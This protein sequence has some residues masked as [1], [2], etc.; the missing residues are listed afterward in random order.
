MQVPTVI[1]SV[2]LALVLPYV[3]KRFLYPRPIPGIPYDPISVKRFMGD[4]PDIA[5][6]YKDLTQWTV[7]IARRSL[8]LGSPI[9]QVFMRPFSK[10]FVVVD[11]PREVS[12]I[13]NRRNREFDRTTVHGVWRTLLPFSTIAQLSTP[14]FKAQRKAWQDAMAPDF[15]RRVVAGHVYSATAGLI[16]LWA[17]RA[18]QTG[19]RPIDVSE[20]FSF[21]ALDAIW[22]ATFGENLQLVHSEIE[23]LQTGKEPD[24]KGL[25]MHS[26]VGYINQ[27]AILWRGSLWPAFSTWRIQR[28]STFRKYKEIRDRE[29]DRILR[30]ATARFKRV[31]NGSGDGEEYETCVMDMVLRRNMLAAQKAGKPTPDATKDPRI[32]DE[33]LLFI[34]AGHDT[35]STTLQWFVKYMTNNPSSQARLRAALRSAFPG[36]GLPDV[37]QILGADVPYLSAAMEETLRC[38]TPASRLTRVATVDT[39]ILGHR[40]PAGT[41]IVGNAYVG[42]VPTPVPEN[43]RSPSS[44]AAVEKAGRG[45]WTRGPGALDLDTFA[46]ERWLRV[47]KK[48]DEVFDAGALPQNAFGGGPRGCFG[49]R[50]AMIELKIMIVLVIMSFK[51]LSL[52]PEL[53][54]SQVYEVLLRTPR[55][56]FV[57]LEAV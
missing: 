7:P 54:S 32:R 37:A 3:L 57:K 38:A 48:G 41:E 17:V 31:L 42:W 9:H 27:L 18:A 11:D 29:I 50:L 10:P 55:Q 15:L 22:T 39:E 34:Y 36:G 33:L 28:S 12:D 51:L 14:E 20:D 1:G 53:N 21:A 52:P 43:A 19:G 2:L 5:A 26:T 30:D 35:T 46:P 8:K 16:K 47:D 49:R 40:I 6:I 44:R 45:D 4:A 56:C 13:V 25:D 24:P 23:K